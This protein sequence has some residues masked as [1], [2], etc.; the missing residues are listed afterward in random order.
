MKLCMVAVAFALAAGLLGGC[1]SDRVDATL[2]ARCT[3]AADCADRCLAAGADFPGG[4]CSR[5][6]MSD[7][8]CPSESVCA[9][10]GTGVCLYSCRDDGDCSF[11]GSVNGQK[12]TCQT[13]ASS[14]LTPVDV[15]LGPG[16]GS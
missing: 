2:G 13:V 4:M 5:D 3:R 15:C 16:G 14:A 8:E 9:S 6:C 10:P 1:S 12:W 7:D 11:L